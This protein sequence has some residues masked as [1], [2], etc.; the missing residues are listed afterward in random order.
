[1]IPPESS[2]RDYQEAAED[3]FFVTDWQAFSQRSNI[4]GIE[5]SVF[6]GRE[7]ESEELW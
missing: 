4:R 6:V 2:P 3:V 5:L 7:E 1:M